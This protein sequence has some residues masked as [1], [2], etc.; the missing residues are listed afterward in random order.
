MSPTSE[1]RSDSRYDRLHSDSPPDNRSA[2][3]RDR[4]RV[5]YTSAFRRLAGVTQVA[6][7]DEGHVFHNRLTHSLE[8][9]Q[10][11]RRVA[12][13]LSREQP[14]EAGELGLDPDVAEAAALAHD[15]GHPPFGHT[16]EKELDRLVTERS[17]M[18]GFEGNP[19]SFRIVTKL[20]L[21]S[22]R[23]DGLNLTR[24]TL[25]AM[26]KY[27][28]LRGTAGKRK[29]KW[30]AYHTEEP[31][32][33]WASELLHGSSGTRTAEA[34]IMDW[35]DDVTYAVHD[36]ADF[37]RAGL[38]PLER[39]C[40]PRDEAERRRFLDGVFALHPD[41]EDSLGF[42][43]KELEESFERMIAFFAV[44][45]R[46]VGSKAQRVHLRSQSAGLIS[47][48]VKA[49]SLRK[50]ETR[51]AGPVEIDPVAQREVAMLKQLTWQYVILNPALTTK[52]Y[53]QRRVVGQLFEIFYD[54]AADSRRR[55]LSIFPYAFR[56]LFRSTEG[57]ANAITRLVADLIASMTEQQA[58]S[59]CLRLTGVS[60]GSA[61]GY[62]VP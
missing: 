1:L 53:G 15:L 19:Q 14:A 37:F 32:L 56:D 13:K 3:Q 49:I 40:A 23:S 31:E 29:E 21:R 16:V 38:I 30:G 54:A 51:G 59:L 20:S 11:A 61:L 22:P 10:V 7:A 43:K 34:S 48:Y 57:D 55:D 50:G 47:T 18:D 24:A 28:W 27:P 25:A 52:Q 12:E 36:A 58:V 62:L 8:V 41:P 45:E 6:S 26:L 46:Y 60:M 9:A 4:D 42:P 35:A 17:V 2:G 44:R 5:L 39:L 33:V